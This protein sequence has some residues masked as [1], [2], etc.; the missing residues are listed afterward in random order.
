MKKV[1][2]PLTIISSIVV[3]I[4]YFLLSTSHPTFNVGIILTEEAPEYLADITLSGFEESY[5]DYFKAS[6]IDRRLSINNIN[7]SD[8]TDSNYNTVMKNNVEV[9][10]Y[11][12]ST[13]TSYYLNSDFFKEIYN[14]N[15]T[16]DSY[17]Y[18]LVITS[19]PI[20]DWDKGGYGVYGE[21]NPEYSTTLS[22]TYYF[23]DKTNFSNN[24]IKQTG[25][26]ENLHMLG[27]LHNP[28]NKNGI[29]QYIPKSTTLNL[30]S[31][32][33]VQLPIRAH[34][35]N[36]L[37]PIKFNKLAYITQSI[38][39][40]FVLP[41]IL[42]IEML[43]D[44]IT[45]KITK[46]KRIPRIVSFGSIIFGSALLFFYNYSILLFGLPIVVML[47]VHAVYWEKV[48]LSKNKK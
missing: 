13:N 21:A 33:E 28:F 2:G 9:N 11:H 41:I 42:L 24:S 23:M 48:K 19:L 22:S 44:F 43:L 5:T 32:Y 30:I 14:Q 1:L 37:G 18:Y 6:L 4:V 10:A 27:Y 29:M 26:H 38:W 15:F 46:K 7:T 31:Y 36:L 12:I 35:A 20:K 25:V 47:S 3:L 17:D 39:F 8:S 16:N 40:L 45:Q 34:V